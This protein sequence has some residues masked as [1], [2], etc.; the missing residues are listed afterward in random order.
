M[1]WVEL[2]VNK[3]EDRFLSSLVVVQHISTCIGLKKSH[4]T[5]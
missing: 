2:T 5:R 1:T 3:S 4:F